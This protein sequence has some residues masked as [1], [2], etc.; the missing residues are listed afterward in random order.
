MK[1]PLEEQWFISDT[2]FGHGNIIKYSRQEFETL[3]Q[4]NMTLV[5]NWN[6]VVKPNDLVW[7]LGDFA[8]TVKAAKEIRPLLN[9]TIRLV[10][11]NHDD[12]TKLAQTGMFQRI[13]MWRQFREHGFT[14]THVPMRQEQIRHGDKNLHGHVHGVLDGLESFHRDVSCESINHTPI[15]FTKIAKWAVEKKTD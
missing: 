8:W 9:G 10:A 2:H 12:I 6:S 4:M 15:N 7:H 3:N 1:R 14:A 13:Y 11:G 5:N